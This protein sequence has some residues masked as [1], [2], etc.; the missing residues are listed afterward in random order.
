MLNI[1]I[2]NLNNDNIFIVYL[3][4]QLVNTNYYTCEDFNCSCLWDLL[5][6][7]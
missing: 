1:K 5:T 7:L 6:F 3:I 2:I 4:K